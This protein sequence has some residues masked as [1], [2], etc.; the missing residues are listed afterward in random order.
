MNVASSDKHPAWSLWLAV[1]AA[2]LLLA[3]GWVT[4][5]RVAHAAHIQ[6]VPL[7]TKGGR[8]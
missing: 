8:P 7:A 5:F 1:A 6:S 4:L 2:F 3:L